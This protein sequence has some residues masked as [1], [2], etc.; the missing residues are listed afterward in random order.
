MG[1]NS[2]PMDAELVLCTANP[3]K[4]A[5]LK[6][7]LPGQWRVLGLTDVGVIEDIPESGE[8]L[9]ANAELKARHV[10]ERT[11]LPCIA[12][13]TGLEVAA[14]GGAPGVHSARYAG[15]A[16]DPAANM[17]K[18][19]DALAGR[20]DRDAR[21]RTV[22]AYVDAQGTRCFEGEVAGT[23]TDAPRGSGGFG[24]DPVFLPHMSTLTFAELDP[25][26]KNAISH[27]GRAVWRL[28]EWLTEHHRPR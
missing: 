10:F 20:T 18:L 16:R 26:R 19:L 12:D 14:L 17:R 25:A 13:D 1:R 9:E 7:M 22:I 27:R 21:F 3:G 15:P 5:E 4:V 11:G 6:A 28:V 23:I 8:T 2:A 24:Y